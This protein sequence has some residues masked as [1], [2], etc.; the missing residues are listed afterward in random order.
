VVRAFVDDLV[1]LLPRLPLPLGVNAD[2]VVRVDFETTYEE[3]RRRKR[4]TGM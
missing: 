3:A 4:L 1:M 2:L